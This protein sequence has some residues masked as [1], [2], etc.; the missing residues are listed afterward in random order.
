MNFVTKITD[1][2]N[3]LILTVVQPISQTKI[4]IAMEY[5]VYQML[6][7]SVIIVT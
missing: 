7:A 6:I 3:V 2:P 4:G 5:H 1:Y